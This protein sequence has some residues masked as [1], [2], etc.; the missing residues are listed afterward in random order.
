MVKPSQKKNKRVSYYLMYSLAFVVIAAL[1]FVWFPLSGRSLVWSA[2]GV[3]QHLVSMTYYGHY[4]RDIFHTLITT[5]K[6]VAPHFDFSIGYGSDILTTLNWYAI[7]DPLNLLFAA[8]SSS[9]AAYLYTFLIIFRLYLMGIAFSAY[10]NKMKLSRASQLCGSLAYVFCGF[11]FQALVHPNFLNPMIYLPLLFIGVEQ[12]IKKQRPYFFVIAVFLAAVTDFYFF[13]MLTIL[14]ILYIVIRFFMLVKKQRVKKFLL[15][16]GR[17]ALFYGAGLL[18]ACLLFLPVVMYMLSTSR[19]GTHQAI[20]VF[21]PATYYLSLLPAFL[22]NK[23][24]GAWVF[25]GYSA[26]SFIAVILL[27]AKRKSHAV[28]KFTLILLTVFLLTPVVGDV[29]NGLSYVANRWI[30]GYSFVIALVTAVMLPDILRPTKRQLKI[31]T[32]VT[33]VFAL[34]YFVVTVVSSSASARGFIPS[35]L[36]VVALLLGMW[37]L[38]LH[39]CHGRNKQSNRPNRATLW[40][41]LVSMCLSFAI[42]AYYKN[43]PAQ[44]GF[45]FQF[46]GPSNAAKTLT[47]NSSSVVKSINDTSFYR[48]DENEYGGQ[49]VVQNRSML[50]GVNSTGSYFSLSNPYMI[51]Y[52]IDDINIYVHQNCNIC[53]LDNRTSVGTLASVKYFVVKDGL[54]RYLPYGY[55]KLVK[56]SGS[57]EV[58]KNAYALPLG[59]TYDK[60]IPKAEYE[61]LSPVEKRQALLQGAVIENSASVTLGTTTPSFTD[62][63]VPYQVVCSPAVSR[64]GT[65]FTVT[66]K[67]ASATLSFS[68]L[69]DCETYLYLKN[70]NYAGGKGTLI[71]LTIGSNNIE[72][73]INY[74]TPAY[75]WYANQHD[76]LVNL[77]Y[78]AQGKTKIKITFG[79]KGTYSLDDLQVICQPMSAYPAQVKALKQATLKQVH[80]GADQVTGSLHLDAPKLLCL[81]IPYSSGWTARVDGKKADVLNVNGMWCGL[82]LS[83]GDY[84]IVLDYTTPYFSQGALLSL[85][86]LA[87]FVGVVV[88]Y[89]AD[90]AR[91]K[92]ALAGSE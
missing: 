53:T 25:F 36:I 10:C 38:Y 6:F 4:I 77:G 64:E 70:L 73:E 26:L 89:E 24:A 60:T 79:A 44:G 61:K 1:V 22:T 76:Y 14:L 85:T 8:V 82:S 3:R 40:L 47:Q 19:A 18:M 59:Y 5:G 23:T 66:K 54:E 50:Q 55:D 90:K 56:K 68:G 39:R 37:G 74:Q 83:A 57:Y 16:V 46:S 45:V 48:Y 31:A 63:I 91:R 11:V 43:A 12:V 87:I 30:F 2:D 51:D 9:K 72:K 32:I 42:G 41:V 75:S 71:P 67:G 27:F 20:N 35:Y 92:K 58:Y 33:A 17:F 80:I 49:D 21:Y 28:L 78:A 52:F 65:T 13:Y 7:G 81:T 86:G 34:A 29:F 69:K 84:N 15:W 88:F 62:K